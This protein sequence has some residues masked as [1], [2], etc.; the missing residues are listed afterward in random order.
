VALK[1]LDWSSYKVSD[2]STDIRGWSLVDQAGAAVGKIKDLLFDPADN[3][4]RYA[5]ADLDGREVMVPIGQ[6]SLSEND[7]RA[8]ATGYTRERLTSLRTYDG[9]DI[10]DT[11]EREV[12][13]E[14]NPGWNDTDAMDYR[15]E[16]YRGNMPE[17]IQLLEEEL[18]LGKRSV[19][20][21]EVEIGKRAVTEQVSEDITL[22]NERLEINRNTVNRPVEGRDSVI[23][24]GETIKVSLYGEE[25]VVEKKA[26]VTEEIEVNKVKDVRT[27]TVTDRVSHEELVTNGLENKQHEFVSAEP[28]DAELRQRRTIDEKVDILPVD[29]ESGFNRPL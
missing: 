7:R 18:R 19:K 21:G 17:R 3:E 24:S 5:L 27:E 26:F 20:T 11:S 1:K 16:R 13:R 9:N 10:D 6:I 28:T 4:V 2:D 15:S 8:T 12:Y 29:D 23:G 25:P 14:H 22:E